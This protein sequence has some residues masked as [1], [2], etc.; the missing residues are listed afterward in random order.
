MTGKWQ[1]PPFQRLAGAAAL[2]EHCKATRT[3]N[4]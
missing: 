1:N 2:P 3:L 4:A